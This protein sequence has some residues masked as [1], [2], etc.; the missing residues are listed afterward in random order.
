MFFDSLC[1]EFEY[2]ISGKGGVVVRDV[3]PDT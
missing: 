1:N 3:A 2:S